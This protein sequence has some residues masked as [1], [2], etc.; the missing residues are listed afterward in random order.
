MSRGSKET[1]LANAA[2]ILGAKGGKKG[3]PAR[4]KA[5]TAKQREAIARKGGEAKARKHSD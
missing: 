3:G 2:R 5:L 1:A 4:A